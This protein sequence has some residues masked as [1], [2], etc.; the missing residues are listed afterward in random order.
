MCFPVTCPTC[1]S[2]GWG[3]CGQHVDAVMAS[4]P[5][6]DRCTCSSG[7]ADGGRRRR[8]LFSLFRS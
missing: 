1:G 2:T 6:A 8:S 3:G 4:V 7:N 5:A